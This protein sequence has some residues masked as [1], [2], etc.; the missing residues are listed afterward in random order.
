[1]S[2]GILA[3]FEGVRSA[4]LSNDSQALTEL[5]AED[6]RGFDPHGTEHDRDMMLEAYRPGGVDLDVYETSDVTSQVIGE[7]GLLMGVGKLS[8]RY[9]EHEFSHNLRFL[10]VYVLRDG[11][12][13][14]L[15]SQV[16]EIPEAS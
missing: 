5:V 7:I 1:M 15:V 16:T 3:A 8:G 10:D 12:W 13:R 14:L 6:Y 2:N 4:L 11:S 9:E